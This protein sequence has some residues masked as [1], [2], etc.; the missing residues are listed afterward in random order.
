[1]LE[2]TLCIQDQPLYLAEDLCLPCVSN[3]ADWVS[4]SRKAMAWRKLEAAMAI[5]ENA[6]P[7]FCQAQQDLD[8]YL[9]GTD[10]TPTLYP[11]KVIEAFLPAFN[12]RMHKRP[13]SDA[14]RQLVCAGL[15]HVMRMLLQE[16]EADIKGS[17]P[18][19]L[20]MYLS[21]RDG[22]DAFLFPGSLREESSGGPAQRLNHDSYKLT[23]DDGGLPLKV[24]L[25]IKR[26]RN[27]GIHYDIPVIPI[28]EALQPVTRR[29]GG[30]SLK[31]AELIILEAEGDANATQSCVLD[32]ASY[33]LL[34][35]IDEK[36][37][38][39]Q[40]LLRTYKMDHSQMNTPPSSAY[41]IY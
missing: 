12:D 22:P 27:S 19:V 37:Q 18:E 10:A 2:R 15:G 26:G 33:C 32:F 29:L 14:S 39:R 8:D 24:P 13:V 35:T 25:Q 1:M 6:Q 40:P 34:Q 9:Q 36:V 31:I 17:L 41:L 7:L 28:A 38:E 4:H 16:D 5:P 21:A 11:A 20:T 23:F 3:E 30:D